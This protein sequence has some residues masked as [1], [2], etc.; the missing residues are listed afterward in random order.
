MVFKKEIDKERDESSKEFV[1]WPIPKLSND[2]FSE[3][4]GKSDVQPRHMA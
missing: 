1:I 4:R 2:A 3:A